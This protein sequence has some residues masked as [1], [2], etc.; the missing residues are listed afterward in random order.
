MRTT[1]L[2]AMLV[3]AC[4]MYGQTGKNRL[5]DWAFGGFERPQ[6]INPIVSPNASNKFYCPITKDSVAWEANDTFNPAAAVYKGKIVVLYR[7][8]DF[9]G[10]GIGNRTSRLGYASSKDGINFKRET[11]PVLYPQNDQQKD[12]EWPGGC[13]DPRVVMTEDGLYVMMYTQWNRHIARLAIA[14]SRNLKDWT[15]HGPA[16]GKAYNGKFVASKSASIVTEVVKGKQVIK[17]INGKY[18]MYWG[19]ANVHAATSDDL[20]NWTPL[21]NEDGSLKI[22]FS[23]REGYFDSH[24]TECGPPA[25]YTPKGI[26]LFYNG[27]NKDG[28]K[29]DQRFTGSSYAAGQALFDIN[30]PTR[31]IT[32]L[33]VPFLRPMDEFE[34]SGQ[35]PAGTVFIEGLVY[36]KNKWHLFYGCAD[37]RV[38]T[39]I[40][41]PKRPAAPDPLP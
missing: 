7:A 26:I 30:D 15:K 33:D 12:L 5:P 28:D 9:Y 22:L 11:T 31:L 24:L 39:A 25:I 41:D 8:E 21:V 23:P 3:T 6:G 29:G 36:F 17:K 35:Y 27:K 1:L 20:I 40:Y 32:R 19:E 34:K 10:E 2:F 18:F 16:F 14:T 37:S 13:E 4:S 38:G